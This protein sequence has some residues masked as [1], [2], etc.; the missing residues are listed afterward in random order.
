MRKNREGKKGRKGIFAPPK[1][2]SARQEEMDISIYSGFAARLKYRRDTYSLCR[3]LREG[4]RGGGE[5]RGMEGRWVAGGGREGREGAG[6]R[7][8]KGRRKNL[9]ALRP[10]VRRVAPAVPGVATVLGRP[11]T[12]GISRGDEGASRCAFWCLRSVWC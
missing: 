12:R 9:L 2:S 8:E 1:V 7:K 11:R 5:G 3:F 4:Q 10:V 6:G